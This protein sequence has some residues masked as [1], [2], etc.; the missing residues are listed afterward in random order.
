MG[1][2]KLLLPWRGKPIIHHVLEAW[3]RS[4]VTHVVVV[5][6]KDDRDLLNALSGFEAAIV[7]ADPPPPHM[8]DS[9]ELGL[10]YAE[11]AYS[12]GPE[13]V[14]L[15]APADMPRLS[16][17]IVDRLLA[18]HDLAAPQILVPHAGG[19]NGHPVLFPWPLA[20][21]VAALGEDEGINVLRERFPSRLV[22]VEDGAFDDLDTPEDYRRLGDS[23]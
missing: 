16:P 18:E 21:E 23:S 13:D 11:C 22:A 19:V 15:L 1:R 14:W 4:R 17:G 8:K 12:P 2:A 6:R 9:V 7:A 20:R 5:V 10:S 3:Q